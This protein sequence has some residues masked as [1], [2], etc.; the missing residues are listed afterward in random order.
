MSCRGTMGRWGGAIVM[1]ASRQLQ[2]WLE[3]VVSIRVCWD[4]LNAS[5]PVADQLYNDLPIQA[6]GSLS[7]VV[8]AVVNC[9][10][11]SSWGLVNEDASRRLAGA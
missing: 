6:A 7:A 4:G 3:W 8:D 5:L 1:C 11:L 2:F 10:S 9:R